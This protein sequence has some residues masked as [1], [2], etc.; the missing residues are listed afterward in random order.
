MTEPKDK[1]FLQET[2]FEEDYNPEKDKL[3]TK[4]RQKLRDKYPQWSSDS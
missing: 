3:E 4:R 1:K 2:A